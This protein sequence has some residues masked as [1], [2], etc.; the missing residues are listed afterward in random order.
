MAGDWIPMQKATASKPEIL[1]IASILKC[2]VG[3]AFLGCFKFWCW[4]DDQLVDGNARG[5]T[6][7]MLDAILGSPGLCKALVEVDWLQARSGSLVVPHFDRHLSESAKKRALS[8]KRVAAHRAKTCNA[9][10]VTEALPQKRTE[11]NRTSNKES[12]GRFVPPSVEEVEAFCRER[13][14]GIDSSYFVSYYAAR[15]WRSGKTKLTDW[16]QCIYTWERNKS[17]YN[18][19]NSPGQVHPDDAGRAFRDA[20]P[21]NAGADE[22]IP[23]G[24]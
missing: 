12:N 8:G 10:S 23:A 7:E 14:N 24:R 5:V 3:D 20:D 9:P 15:G 13:N 17:L 2:S 18:R 21:G 16:K 4:C 6:A 19:S 11:E 22:A 1:R